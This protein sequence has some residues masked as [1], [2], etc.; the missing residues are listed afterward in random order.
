MTRAYHPFAQEFPR[1]G[2]GDLEKFRQSIAEHGLIDKIVVDENGVILDGISRYEML[3]AIGKDPEPNIKVVRGL[4]DEQKLQ[5]IF[6]RN[7][8]RRHLSKQQRTAMAVAYSDRLGE[9][10]GEAR[11]RQAVESNSTTS[12]GVGSKTS[13][14]KKSGRASQN[15]AVEIGTNEE[16]VKVCDNLKDED[17]EMLQ[18]VIAGNVSIPE[19]K[20]SL[21][22]KRAEKSQAKVSTKPLVHPNVARALEAR[23]EFMRHVATLKK[24]A[25]DL[26]S[27]FDG[28][29]GAYMRVDNISPKITN[30]I[31]TIVASLPYCACKHC[32]GPGCGRCKES[33]YITRARAEG[34]PVGK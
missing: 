23:K 30:I 4:N 31:E 28:P 5:F 2:D 14:V 6:D 11:E 20:K 3:L 8:H 13:Q 15:F 10:K 24:V 22:K 29:G 12:G 32:G 1:M 16:Y 7:I 27:L 17:P 33:G 9:L 18:E 21:A 34:V 25:E 26:D 19:A